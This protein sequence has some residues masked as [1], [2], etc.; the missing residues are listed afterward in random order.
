[1][2]GTSF[3]PL[4][5]ALMSLI[6]FLATPISTIVA[7][8]RRIWGPLQLVLT[9]QLDALPVVKPMASSNWK[10]TASSLL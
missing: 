2:E 4:L 10:Q 5:I 3:I 6:D 9:Y 1:M 7:S 8:K